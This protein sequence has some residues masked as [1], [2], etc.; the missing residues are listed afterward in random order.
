[1][2][3][4][5]KNPIIWVLGPLGLHRALTEGFILLHVYNLAG[6][7]LAGHS[8][9]DTHVS[10]LRTWAAHVTL[11]HHAADLSYHRIFLT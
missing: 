1:M 4:G 7:V 9:Q 11:W 3:L 6:L 5:T 2:V 8:I 10:V